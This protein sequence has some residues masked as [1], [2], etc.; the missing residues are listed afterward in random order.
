[1]TRSAFSRLA[2]NQS[3]AYQRVTACFSPQNMFLM[4]V[5]QAHSKGTDPSRLSLCIPL[6]DPSPV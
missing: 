6:G 1:M 3:K 2:Q 4:A 5:N